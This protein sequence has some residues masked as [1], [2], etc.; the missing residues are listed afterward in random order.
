MRNED[1]LQ[2][3]MYSLEKYEHADIF[4]ERTIY[5]KNMYLKN[6]YIL[7]CQVRDTFL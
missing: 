6:L 4:I 2:M 3:K 5:L 1:E 7:R